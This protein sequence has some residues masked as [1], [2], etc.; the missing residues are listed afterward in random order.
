MV[1]GF[2]AYDSYNLYLYSCLEGC[3]DTFGI[4]G[5]KDN[6]NREVYE[7]SLRDYEWSLQS[8]RI[9]VV[10]LAISSGI[11]ERARIRRSLPA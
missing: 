3:H 2:G 8:Q 4:S 11:P 6:L 5:E 10:K 7:L 9:L 1:D